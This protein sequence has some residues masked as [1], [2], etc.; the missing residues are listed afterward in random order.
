MSKSDITRVLIVDDESINIMI[1][2]G[3]LN[4]DGVLVDTASSG[5]EALALCQEQVYD[6]ILLDHM[7]EGIDGVETLKRLKSMDSFVNAGTYVVAMTGNCDEGARRMYIET[8]FDDYVAKPVSP[9]VIQGFLTKVGYCFDKEMPGQRL[10]IPKEEQSFLDALTKA[11][12]LDVSAGIEASADPVVYIQAVK[13]FARSA[14]EKLEDIDMFLE[15]EDYLSYTISVHGL[16]STARL[17]GAI[18]LSEMAQRL[19]TAGQ[20]E[21][22]EYIGAHNPEL[23][24][25]YRTII[26][27]VNSIIHSQASA[28]LQPIDKDMWLDALSEIRGAISAFDIDIVMEILHQLED[29]SLEADMQIIYEKLLLAAD[30]VDFARMEEV[31]RED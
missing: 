13:N 14:D 11:G 2:K 21:D 8:G 16:K 4:F 12:L 24:D 29:Y 17:V 6:L 31:L 3:Q 15:E 19:E 27:S 9:D 7:M 30:N 25:E 26:H 10:D 20:D 23:M 22:V 5:S 28:D 18:K 1:V